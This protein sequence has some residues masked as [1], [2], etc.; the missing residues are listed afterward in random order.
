MVSSAP[1][2]DSASEE[3]ARSAYLIVFVP[4]LDEERTVG[5]VVRGVPQSIP[6]VG[7]IEVVVVDDGSSDATAERAAEAGA[8]VIRHPTSQGVGAAFHSALAHG[9]DRGADLI[10][11]IDADGQFDPADIP[12]LVAP[13]V[14][15]EADLAT[16]SRFA[17]PALV[18][19]MPWAKRWGNRVMSRLISRLAGQTLYDVSCGMRCYSRRAALQLHLLGRFTYTQEVV[20]NLAFKGLRI[21]EVPIRVRGEREFGASRVAGNLWQYA[22]RTVRII[23]RSYRDYYPLRFFGGIALALLVPAVLLAAFLLFHYLATGAFSPQK[24]AGF[25]ALGLGVIALLVLH[26]GLI[27]DMLGRHR[28][29]L[30]ELLYRQRSDIRQERN[31]GRRERDFD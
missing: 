9:I 3:V 5:S 28:I 8:L 31:G 1:P 7:L 14:A 2:A 17:D 4:A 10:L 6:G 20:L 15:G 18:P 22:W 13:V 21:V 30:E 27:G 25:T 24:W 12:K 16:A 26:V 23:L 19:E 29:Y 11:S